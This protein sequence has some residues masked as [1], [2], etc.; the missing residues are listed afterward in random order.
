MDERAVA[1]DLAGEEG[2][3]GARGFGGDLE[4]ERCVGLWLRGGGEDLRGGAGE[5]VGVVEESEGVDRLVREGVGA[6]DGEGPS[7]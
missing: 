7:I 6:S 4:V 5:A 1:L 2:L 3:E